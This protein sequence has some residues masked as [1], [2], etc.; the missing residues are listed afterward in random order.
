MRSGRIE[1]GILG[2]TGTVGQQLVAELDGHPWFRVS[3]LAASARSAGRTYAEAAPWRV[4]APRPAAAASLRVQATEPGG[5]PRLVF[6]ALD[7]SAAGEIERGLRRRRPPRRQQRAQ[8]P[9]GSARA[10]RR[11]GDQRRSSRTARRTDRGEGMGRRDRDQPEL[12]DGRALDGPRAAP[13]VRPPVGDGLDPAGDFRRRLSRR[14]VAR[15]HRER[16][17]VHRR[18]GGEDRGRDA[19][20]PRP[21]R[22]GRHRAAPGRR[23]RA[24]QP[25]A[26]RQRPYRDGFGGVRAG[27]IRGGSA[28]GLRELHRPAAAGRPPVG[29][30]AP[31][32]LP[33]G[34]GPAAAA[35][36]RRPRP[37]HDGVDRSRAALPGARLEV[38][39]PRPQ[40]RSRRRRRGGS[41]RRDDEGRRSPRVREALTASPP[42]HSDR[43][44]TVL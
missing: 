16:H 34:A 18:R 39:G 29:A 4:P 23:E 13:A 3:W 12:L 15:H 43:T 2:A 33:S 8:P 28:R 32:G 44:V 25:R 42:H 41:Q 27:A 6:S 30:A 24:R 14:P 11:P 22:G 35:S 37:R 26:R 17:P 10:A 1:V 7:G 31:A 36:R 19:E 5:A 9:D 40:H 38:R 21:A 20:D